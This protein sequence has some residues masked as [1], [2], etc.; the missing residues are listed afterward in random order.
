M[1][2]D[3]GTAVADAIRTVRVLRILT[4][5]GVGGANMDDSRWVPGE[6]TRWYESEG[7]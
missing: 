4:D 5:L 6:W 1:V 3:F 2:T 7:V